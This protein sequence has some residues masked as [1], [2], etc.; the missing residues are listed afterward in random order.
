MG[1]GK[2]SAGR[3]AAGKLGMS[4]IDTDAV[5][6]E[7]A[8]K[9]IQEI[10]AESCE[11]RFRDLEAEAISDLEGLDNAV[12]A[13]GGGAVLRRM[14]MRRLRLNGLVIHLDA[15]PGIL[16]DRLG[17]SAERP[18]LTDCSPE[19]L[20]KHLKARAPHYLQSDWKIDSGGTIE[21]TADKICM[22]ASKPRV[23]ICAC[24]SGDSPEQDMMAAAAGGATMV[25]L[26]LDLME[27]RDIVGLVRGSPLPVIATDRKCGPGL[28]QAIK[29]GCE[30]VD[31]DLGSKE[32]ASYFAM[33]RKA[34]C[35]VIASVHAPKGMP[36]ELPD[37]GEADLLKLA[38]A[39]DSREDMERLE[40]LQRTLKDAIIVPMGKAGK[41]M[42]V[43]MPLLGSYL[44]YCYIG[45]NTGEGQHE[46]SEIVGLYR[47]MGLR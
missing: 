41:D 6:E 12:I 18:L 45:K 8:G 13:T 32:Y 35:R 9:P 36:A 3:L 22:I 23:R 1:S 25:E 33:A 31:L 19:G 24:I 42:R 27:V 21:V 38:V 7:K 20:E 5:V 44:A 30:F 37:K 34:G 43:K 46:L 10:F 16:L 15:A 11:T 26:R 40:G 14:N 28:G 17:G 47:G 39:V 2:T 29:A 4:Y